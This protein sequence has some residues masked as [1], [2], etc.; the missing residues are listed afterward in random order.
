MKLQKKEIT[1]KCQLIQKQY[2]L[3]Q[4]KTMSNNR[5]QCQYQLIQKQCRLIEKCQYQLKKNNVN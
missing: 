4:K 1:G 5:K 3:I 2:Q